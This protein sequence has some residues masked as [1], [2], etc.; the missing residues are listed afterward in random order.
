MRLEKRPDKAFLIKS[1]T[2][3][4]RNAQASHQHGR[5]LVIVGPAK[6]ASDLYAIVRR[7]EGG[8]FQAIHHQTSAE[9]GVEEDV[10]GTAEVVVGGGL[11]EHGEAFLRAGVGVL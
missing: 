6:R 5:D 4:V 7:I 1:L 9:A 11:A 8:F 2:R 10:Q 3:S